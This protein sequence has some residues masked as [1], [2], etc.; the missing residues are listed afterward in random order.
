MVDGFIVNSKAILLFSPHLTG[1][2]G[3][4]CQDIES[5]PKCPL[6]PEAASSHF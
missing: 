4:Y 2:L 5:W 1:N 3:G 6:A